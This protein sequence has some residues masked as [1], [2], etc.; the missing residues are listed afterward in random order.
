MDYKAQYPIAR[1]DI[2]KWIQEDAIKRQFHIVEG[3]DNAPKA[4]PLLFSGGNTGKLCVYVYLSPLNALRT[5]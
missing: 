2:G 4:L 5:E 3:I 1:A